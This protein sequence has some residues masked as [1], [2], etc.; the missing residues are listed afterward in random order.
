MIIARTATTWLNHPRCSLRRHQTHK[1]WSLSPTLTRKF[2]RSA[3]GVSFSSQELEARLGLEELQVVPL[4]LELGLLPPRRL[5]V[6]AHTELWEV[7]W[8]PLHTHIPSQEN[9][10]ADR[11]EGEAEAG[12]IRGEPDRQSQDSL[13]PKSSVLLLFLLRSHHFAAVAQ[14]KPVKNKGS[15][16]PVGPDCGR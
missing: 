12:G 15:S 11:L 9:Q 14:L 10:Q 2:M 4:A 7:P 5:C 3:R 8:T 16:S 6:S 13:W 1:T